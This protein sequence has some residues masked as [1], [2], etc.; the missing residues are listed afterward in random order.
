MLTRITSGVFKSSW[1]FLLVCLVLAAIYL[2]MGRLL[3]WSVSFN[4]DQIKSFLQDNGLEFVQLGEIQGGWAVYDPRF[5]VRNLTLGKDGVTAL[6]VDYLSLRLDSLRSALKQTPIIS[7]VEISGIRLTLERDDEGLWIRGLA[8]GDGE[9]SL[10]SLLDS[11]PYL[12]FL[13]LDA[14][15]IDLVSPN[16]ELRLASREGEPWLVSS[17]GDANVVSFPLYLEREEDGKSIQSNRL[18]LRGFYEG[19]LRES[20]FRAQLYLD[21]PHVDL[22]DFLPHVVIA[23]KNLSSAT[24]DTEIWLNITPG[25]VDITGD[26]VVRDVRLGE[27]S[28][29]LLDLVQT[30]FR[31]LGDSFSEGQLTFPSIAIESGEF[32]F[33]SGRVDVAVASEGGRV[34]WAAEM[35]SL[36]V[37]DAV[38][39][40]NFASSKSLLSPR[41]SS[42]LATTSP[43]G[44]LED[45]TIVSGLD[46]GFVSMPLS[47][48]S[49]NKLKLVSH[50]NEFQM[51]SYLGIPAIDSLNGLISIEPDRGYLDIDN[52]QFQL[53]FKSMFSQPWP[54]DSGKGRV[55]YRIADGAFSVFSGLIELIQ[56]DLQAYGKLHLSLPA[57][58]DQQTWGLAIGVKHADLLSAARYIPVTTPR[59]LTDWLDQ[60][61]RGGVSQ[62][63]GLVIHGALFR[64]APAVRKA[65]DIYFNVVGGVVEYH[66]DWPIFH[67]MQ[68]TVHVNNHQVTAAGA[69]GKILESDVLSANVLI[70]LSLTGKV[71]TILVDAIANG[72][73]SDAIVVLNET[74]LS[75][76]TGGMAAAWEGNGPLRA[77]M[78]LNIPLGA[79]IDEEVGA[80]VDV[81]LSS[82]TLRMNDF[83]L[84]VSELEGQINYNNVTGL[85]SPAFKGR[86]FDRPITGT[87]RTD[88]H[89][90]GGE[91]YVDV[92]GSVDSGAL[93]EWSDQILLSRAT[94]TLAYETT[95]HVPFGGSKDEVYVEARSDLVGITVDLPY[96]LDKSDA[97]SSHQF[98]Y[99]QLFMEPGYIVE[100]SLDDSVK[101]SLKVE[102]GIA[103][104]GR[105]HFGE[106][107][108]GAVTYDGIR[109][110]GSLKR[111]DYEDWTLTTERL[112]EISEVSL[113]DEIAEHVASVT[114]TIDEFLVYELALEQVST[115]VTREDGLW[116]AQLENEM[117][118]GKVAV[119]DD[120]EKPLE[121]DLEWLSF[122]GGESTQDPF[123]EVNPLDIGD[124][125]F[126][127]KQL[128]M[129]S[130]DYG[131]WA[132]RF[133]A[134]ESAANFED[135]TAT[136]LGVQVLPG[137]SAQWLYENNQHTTSFR[138]QLL[139]N[140]LAEA[141]QK[142]GFASSIEGEG[143]KLDADVRW[144]GS[145]AMID[146]ESIMGTVAIQEGNGRF[147]QAE[148]GGALKLLGIFDFASLARRLRLD[149]SDV[150]EK[151]FEF[152]EISGV[153][154]FDRGMI[155]VQKPIVI[156]G[157]SGKFTAAGSIDLNS[158]NLDNDMIVTLPV[159]RTLPWYAAYSAFATGPLAGAGVMIAQKVFQN[160]ID[161]MSSA[162]Y[163]ISGTIE[164]PVIEFVSI[165][166]DSVR[167]AKSEP[168][169]EGVTEVTDKVETEVEIMPVIELE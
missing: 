15:D 98:S 79:R 5:E 52:D 95:V 164:E 162:K 160:Q 154:S 137:S 72:S 44:V 94:G 35:A 99:R 145:P 113:H 156:D 131:S 163:K 17:S 138:G 124:I 47:G 29:D 148:T 118:V 133:R 40:A 87:I 153:T 89:G 139:I 101:A 168:D 16:L 119:F 33:E 71:D 58:R 152:T 21:A 167:E 9:F 70:P 66:K 12:E 123:A 10:Q 82:A 68:G 77:S 140:D 22:E 55:A 109:M 19:D 102:D 31:Y 136:A 39:V 90:A 74:P 41:L 3:A 100:L 144:D 67:E 28:D 104:G 20:D 105:V 62:E 8:R 165:F 103:V 59:D 53:Y 106:E 65:H 111:L 149:F 18:E 48:S 61:I 169:A 157:S 6:E 78:S 91:I 50:V 36:L 159:G 46:S 32:G 56:G 97:A 1:W 76:T 85:V 7:E 96:P 27:A 43:S 75:E 25:V 2:S 107:A 108:S 63:T 120:V 30:R 81:S 112:G 129:G 42:M 92:N 57:D 69:T 146:V 161:Q 45:I 23:N 150:V 24:L 51:G 14:I 115:L 141:L 11:I 54:F 126:T 34:L 125:D 134:D 26:V 122:D 121:V 128:L 4:Q 84:T 127:T 80:N 158:R 37:K 86:T 116:L 60:A 88:V 83:D 13:R 143:L 117:L 132:F 114:L 130:E 155:E 49:N 110:T 135:L 93:Y 147:V 64:G 142:F 38:S 73:F 151:G 166:D